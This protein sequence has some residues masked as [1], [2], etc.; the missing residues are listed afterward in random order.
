MQYVKTFWVDAIRNYLHGHFFFSCNNQPAYDQDIA[1][2]LESE[3]SMIEEMPNSKYVRKPKISGKK[4]NV[5]IHS[6]YNTDASCEEIFEYYNEILKVNG[7]EFMREEKV[8]DWGKD[9]GGM[10]ARYRKGEFVA[11]LQYAGEDVSCGWVFAFSINWGK[12]YKREI[13]ESLSS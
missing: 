12:L 9:Y 1:N 8:L 2:L 5:G 11:A 7:W 6:Y 4:E 10:S 13:E 3:F